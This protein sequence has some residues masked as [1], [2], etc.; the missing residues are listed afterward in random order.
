VLQRFGGNRKELLVLAAAGAL[1]PSLADASQVF[2]ADQAPGMGV[3]DLSG[4]GVS[5][6]QL[7]A[8]RLPGP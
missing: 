8:S 7:E 5:G 3:Q 4:D 1:F 2:Q 6:A